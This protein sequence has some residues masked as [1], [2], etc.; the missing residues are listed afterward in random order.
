MKTPVALM[1]FNR[2]DRTYEVFEAIR[3]AKPP[4]LLVVADGPRPDRPEDIA[5]CA[6]ARAII[7][8]VDW[9]CEV[10]KNF[11]DPNLGCRIRV[12][13]G[14]DWVFENAEEAIILEDD[15]IPHPDFF[16][17]CDELLERYRDDERVMH[18][19]GNNFWSSQYHHEES[20]LFSRYTLSWGWATWRRAWQHYDVDMKLWSGMPQQKQQTILEDVLGDE[21]AA[22]TWIRIFQDAIAVN[23]WDYQ[24][25]LTCWLQGGL[26]ILPHVNL[27]SNVGFD[28]DATHTFS[29]TTTSV[30][31]PQLSIST[32]AMDFPLKHPHLTIRDLQIDRFI[33][34]VY[35][36]YFPKLPKRIRSK[37]N[38]IFARKSGF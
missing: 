8:K 32:A 13:T 33:Q 21:H 24:W 31:C 12:A 6:A 30:D 5:K 16:R 17:Y 9:D 23:T 34:D 3:Q 22:K 10:I 19:S 18:I 35:F 38:R 20:Y 11:S 15:C 4:K 26:S 1:I 7:D 36:D 14:I 2:P 29:A 28:A 27:V 37:L 25:T